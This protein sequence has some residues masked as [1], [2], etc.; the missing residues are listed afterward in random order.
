MS[1]HATTQNVRATERAD[2]KAGPSNAIYALIEGRYWA[3]L[4][5]MFESEKPDV[6]AAE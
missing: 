6:V 2:R 4:L 5:I 3:Y 1:E